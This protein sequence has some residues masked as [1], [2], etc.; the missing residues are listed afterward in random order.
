MLNV[1]LVENY[2]PGQRIGLIELAHNVYLIY[3]SVS[4]PRNRPDLQADGQPPEY[5]SQPALHQFTDH[6]SVRRKTLQLQK[7]FH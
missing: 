3:L 7:V 4:G 2:L 5:V 6:V 1:R